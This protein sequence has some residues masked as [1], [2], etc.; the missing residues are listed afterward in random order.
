MIFL[1]YYEDNPRK[2][3]YARLIE[4]V[5]AHRS[6]LGVQPNLILVNEADKD[7]TFAGCEIRVE[8]HI[9][10]NIYHVRRVE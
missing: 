10:L 5:Q 6:R 1:H 8:K 7:A 9:G 4:A 2:P 3:V